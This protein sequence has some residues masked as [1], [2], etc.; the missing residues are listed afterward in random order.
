MASQASDSP[1]ASSSPKQTSRKLAGQSYIRLGT[2]KA[3][4]YEVIDDERGVL[5]TAKLV[6]HKA[7]VNYLPTKKETEGFTWLDW[8]GYF[9]PCIVW[10]RVYNWRGWFIT[11]VLSGLSVGAMVIPQGMSYANLAGLPQVFGLYGAFVPPLVY[12]LFGSSKQLAV[13]PVAVTSMLLGNGLDRMFDFVN[14]NPNQPTDPA[15]QEE[16][17]RAAVQI[18]FIAG[19]MY[20]GVGLLRL[21]WLTNFLSHTVV[22]GFMSGACITIALSQVKY[23]LGISIPRADK[24][25]EQFDNIFGAISGFQWREFVMGMAFIFL[26]MLFK[27]LGSRYKRLFWLRAIGPLT[28]CVISIA[29][30]NIFK[31]Y[32]PHGPKKKPLIKDIGKIPDG[33]PDF[34]ASWFFPLINVGKQLVLAVIVCLV[35]VCESIS[36]ARALA[37]QNHYRLNPTQELRAI[38]FAN[39]AGAFFNCYTTTGSFS[40]S[41]IQNSIGA[42]SQISSFTTGILLMITLLVLTPV[43]THMSANVQGAIIIVGVLQ[44]FDFREWCH[45]WVISKLDWLVWNAVFLFVLFLGVEIGIGVGVGISLVL[46][47]YKTTF[48]HIATLGKLPDSNA[49]RN[50]KMYPGLTT[51]PGI[52]ILR[53]DAPLYYANVENVKDHILEELDENEASTHARVAYLIVD[54]AACNDLDAT[55]IHFFADL[56]KTLKEKGITLILANPTKQVLLALRRGKIIKKIGISAVHAQVS[57]AVAYAEELSTQKTKQETVEGV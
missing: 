54:L 32:Q 34:T 24:I 35:D 49:Y 57:D 48:P 56:I 52:L 20:T 43:F 15:A 14:Q 22:S 23:I 5:E 33:M 10:L 4:G 42:K 6:V 36:I 47:I 3:G 2:K 30:M 28:V 12:S 31:W 17:N 16:Y 50:V 29:L 40:R 46:M 9:L 44:L 11:D 19:L 8:A 38:G 13:G 25:I 41:A 26:L 7:R 27:F 37:Q 45:L 21:G 18:A 55:A 51:H 53:I 39:L 1:K